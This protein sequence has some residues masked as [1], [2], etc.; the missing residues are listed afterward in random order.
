MY[1][2]AQHAADPTLTST[3]D[4]AFIA[5]LKELLLLSEGT[6]AGKAEVI[7]PKE[8]NEVWDDAVKGEK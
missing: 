6:T 2:D 5:L 7:L 3:L 4:E 8:T 1:N